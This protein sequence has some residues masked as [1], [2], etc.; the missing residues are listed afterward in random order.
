[1]DTVPV[2]MNGNPVQKFTA[3]FKKLNIPVNISQSRC[4][5]FGSG[6]YMLDHFCSFFY[7]PSPFGS[8][9][10]TDFPET[11]ILVADTPVFNLMRLF[12]AIFNTPF[13]IFSL[14]FQIA[15]LHP[16]AHF[17]CGARACICTNVRFTACFPAQLYV[18]IRTE[19][20]R[21]LHTPGFV[22]KRLSFFSHRVL[23]VVGGHKTASRP[24]QNG[25]FNPPHC[26]QHICPEAIFIRERRLGIIDTAVN[27]A[28][29]MF[30][31][32]S[33][34]HGASPAYFTVGI[35][36]YLHKILSFLLCA[37]ARH[38]IFQ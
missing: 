11:V 27:L 28:M 17:L 24:A 10:R 12:I 31:K 19:G 18:F 20:V 36:K 23:P 7:K 30:N 14:I 6:I 9:F 1:M 2:F 25:H 4:R 33:V 16:V 35:Q 38:P 13:R 22:K 26:L 5:Q 3:V 8:C 29:E 32:L 15:V 21:I 37:S 34:K